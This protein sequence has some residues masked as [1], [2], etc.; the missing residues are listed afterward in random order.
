MSAMERPLQQ[1]VDTLRQATE[2]RADEELLFKGLRDA[3]IVVECAA[4][5]WYYVK[6]QP[7]CDQCESAISVR[8]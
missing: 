7:D 8:V 1:S 6:D 5:G 3:G 4:C 2:T